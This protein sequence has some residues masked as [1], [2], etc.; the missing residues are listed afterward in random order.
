MNVLK[1]SLIFSIIFGLVGFYL[2]DVA[3]AEKKD[4]PEVIL[5]L[6]LRNSEGQLVSYIEGTQMRLINPFLLDKYLD[7]KQSQIIEKD[8]Q[9]FELIQWQGPTEKI[10]NF[11]S[12]SIFELWVPRANDFGLVLNIKHDAY[13]VEPGDTITVY[14]TVI[15]PI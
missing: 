7:T 2:G 4:L 6:Q 14:W 12:M 3:E 13:Q 15:R 11:H 9:S 5:Q 8:N 1:M 10:D